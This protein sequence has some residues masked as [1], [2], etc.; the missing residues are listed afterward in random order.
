MQRTCRELTIHLCKEPSPKRNLKRR[1]PFFDT[2]ATATNIQLQ[3]SIDVSVYHRFLYQD[4]EYKLQS[5]YNVI[6]CDEASQLTEHVKRKLLSIPNKKIIFL[7][8]IGFQLEPVIDDGELG[9]QYIKLT[10]KKEI[11]LN[12]P[13]WLIQEGH[14]EMKLDDID[15]VKEYTTDYRAT[16]PKLRT[17]KKELRRIIDFGRK[18]KINS[19]E[20]SLS[21]IKKM[22]PETDVRE[23]Y[24]QKDMILTSTHE[25]IKKYNSQFSYIQKYLVKA[26][27]KFFKNGQI[28]FTKPNTKIAKYKNC[29]TD[30]THAFTVHAIQGETLGHNDK[31]YIDTENLF[32][33][34]M[35][36]TAV[37]RAR[38][39]DQIFLIKPF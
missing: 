31:L 17:I 9:K 5:K 8:D 29:D 18:Q 22:I 10:L 16:C 25:S 23:Y 37:S 38:R 28:V 34:R 12:Y 32:S 20:M 4:H 27:T 11:N 13:D 21:Y 39:L 24:T 19:T 36:Y 6:L 35:L 15:N 3:K 7:G 2:T 1:I 14:Y 30:M 26:N 33:E